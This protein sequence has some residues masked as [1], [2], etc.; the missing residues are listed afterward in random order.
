MNE[1][2]AVD[3][4]NG[5]EA[6]HWVTEADRYDGQLAPFGELLFDRAMQRRARSA[7]REHRVLGRRVCGVA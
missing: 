5:D 3:E 7:D 2:E 4:W 6:Q 1:T